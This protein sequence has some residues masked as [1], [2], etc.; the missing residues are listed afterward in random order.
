VGRIGESFAKL[1]QTADKMKRMGEPPPGAVAEHDNLRILRYLAKLTINPAIAHGVA[2]EVGSLEPGKLADVVLWP[3]AFVGATPKLIV[4]RG[5][6]AWS[7]MGDPNAPIPTTEPVL[8]RPMW[9]VFGQAPAATSVTFTSQVALEGGVGDRLRLQK[10]L[11]AA[12]GCRTVTKKQMVRNTARCSF[13]TRSGWSR[14]ATRRG[15]PACSTTSARSVASSWS[16]RMSPAGSSGPWPACSASCCR[17]VPRPRDSRATSA[18][19]RACSPPRPI[20]SEWP[21]VRSWPWP[22]S[23]CSGAAPVSP[24]SPEVGP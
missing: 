14:A 20:G 9:G 12:K 3:I 16:G 5:M 21:S 23:G 22:A 8:Y 19:T 18:S 2:H 11:V 4:R 13:A 6:I 24:T 10:R 7:V 1:Y 15:C 17:A